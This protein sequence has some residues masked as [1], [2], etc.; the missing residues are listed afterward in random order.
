MKLALSLIRFAF[1]SLALSLEVFLHR[2]FGVRYIGLQ[3]AGALLILFV[4]PAMWEGHDVRPLGGFLL[5]FLLMNAVARIGMMIRCWRG[6]GEH[7]YYT[8]RP[9]LMSILRGSSELT[10]KRGY[11]PLLVFLV[12]ALTLPWSQPLGSYLMIAAFG[13]LASVHLQHS[14]EVTKAMDM[15]DAYTEQRNVA[16]RFRRMRDGH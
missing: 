12:G 16:E 6:D 1:D 3:A 15:F 11:E 8:G 14:E 10:V 13:L 9:W 5:A 4:Y 7:S 2:R